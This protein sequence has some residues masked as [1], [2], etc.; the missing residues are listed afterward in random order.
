VT[1][2]ASAGLTAYYVH[3][4]TAMVTTADVVML[5]EYFDG[6]LEA[7][8]TILDWGELKAG[9]SYTWEYAVKNVGTVNCNCSRI[10]DG[11][12]AGWGYTWSFNNTVF[13][14]GQMKTGVLTLTIPV[15]AEGAYTWSSRL[16]ATEAP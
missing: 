16:V 3:N 1:V 10:V 6:Y 15:D 2:A 8:D 11:L 7:N 4:E 13:T 12:P 5:E 9:Q 14:V